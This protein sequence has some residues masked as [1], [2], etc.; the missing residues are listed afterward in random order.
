MDKEESRQGKKDKKAEKQVL[1]CGKCFGKKEKDKEMKVKE[2]T[3]N[4]ESKVRQEAENRLARER[5]NWKKTEE[6]LRKEV[7]Q[8]KI[9]ANRKKQRQKRWKKEKSW[10]LEKKELEEVVEG[11]K[12]QVG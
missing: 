10:V 7:E 6:E 12:D 2:M 9:R 4:I 8:E 11:L 3:K 5:D 1:V